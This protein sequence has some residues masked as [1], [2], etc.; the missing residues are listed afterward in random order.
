M[1]K[2]ETDSGTQ[3]KLMVASWEADGGLGED[4]AGMKCELVARE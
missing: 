1:N 3:N 2:T 4:G